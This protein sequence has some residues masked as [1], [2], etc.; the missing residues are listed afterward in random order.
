MNTRLVMLA[1]C[2]FAFASQAQE[3]KVQMWMWKDASGVVHYSDV[4]GPGAVQVDVN[5]PRG[6][7]DTASPGSSD[8]ESQGEGRG[9]GRGEGASQQSPAPAVTYSSLSIVQ[10]ADGTSFFD[11][12]SVVD[13]QIDSD[14]SLASG[15]SVYLY[16]DGNRVGSSGD[17]MGYSLPNLDR[18]QHTLSSA[19]FDQQGNEKIRSQSIVFYMKPNTIVTPAA[20]GPGVKPRPKPTPHAGG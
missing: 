14:P 20:V 2:L 17:S 12:D 11:A 6:Q 3:S 13:V 4:P 15:D 18:G 9:E 19:I 8:N 7:P 5:V 1:S 10:P 16:L